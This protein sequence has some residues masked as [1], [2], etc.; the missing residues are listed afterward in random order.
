MVGS[1]TATGTT[2]PNQDSDATLTT[3]KS[4][5]A[6]TIHESGTLNLILTRGYRVQGPAPHHR[7]SSATN[8][9]GYSV[10]H[11]RTSRATA[12]VPST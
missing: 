6:L 3:H 2:L 12:A 7:A 9:T 8:G 1:Y 4:A 5:T 11:R 10:P